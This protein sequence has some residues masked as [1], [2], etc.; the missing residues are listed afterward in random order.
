MNRTEKERECYAGR[1]SLSYGQQSAFFVVLRFIFIFYFICL[2]VLPIFVY[3]V[4]AALR[5][6]SD[7]TEC[8]QG[9]L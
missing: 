9:W 1:N 7:P 3:H 6:P 4:P 8:S 2:N 5:K